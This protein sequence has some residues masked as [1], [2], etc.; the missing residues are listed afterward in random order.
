MIIQLELDLQLPE[1][2]GPIRLHAGSLAAAADG[3]P[4]PAASSQPFPTSL[5]RG[6][7]E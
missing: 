7:S 5:V 1:H 6:S 2:R 3:P 4:A